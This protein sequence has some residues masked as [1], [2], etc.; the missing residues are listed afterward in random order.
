MQDLHP[1]VSLLLLALL[2]E[3]SAD[4]FHLR[5][6]SLPNCLQNFELIDGFDTLLLAQ[7]DLGC[8]KYVL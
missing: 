7:L 4:Q 1:V 8:V 3:G 2:H 5:V 6:S